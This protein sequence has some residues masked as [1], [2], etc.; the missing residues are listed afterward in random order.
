GEGQ[1]VYVYFNNDAEAHAVR[2]AQ[3]LLELIT[4]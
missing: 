4:G 1:D 2:N 3:R